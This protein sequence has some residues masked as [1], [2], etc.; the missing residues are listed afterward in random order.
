MLLSVD[1]EDAKYSWTGNAW[2]DHNFIKVPSVL[3]SRLGK[4]VANDGLVLPEACNGPSSRGSDHRG[5]LEYELS[6][7]KRLLVSVNLSTAWR[8]YRHD[9]GAILQTTFSL[10]GVKSM[11]IRVKAFGSEP[12]P[13]QLRLVLE[14]AGVGVSL[15]GTRI[16]MDVPLLDLSG[17]RFNPVL[18]WSKS[19]KGNAYATR[20]FHV[21]G[22]RMSLLL[23]ISP[24]NR[25]PEPSYWDWHR[26]FWPGG[27]PGSSRRH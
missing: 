12:E 21:D 11:L 18:G 5:A 19:K 26:R 3:A 8:K 10:I 22:Q 2:V 7:D 15:D 25:L 27:L 14:E 13:R 6:P 16:R 20:K 4:L 9:W 23:V 17:E 1:F 24:P